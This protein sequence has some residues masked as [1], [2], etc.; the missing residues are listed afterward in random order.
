MSAFTAPYVG[1]NQLVGHTPYQQGTATIAESGTDPTTGLV[2]GRWSGGTATIGGS[3]HALGN[4]SLHYVFGP[5]QSG[6]VSLPLTGTA[7]YDVVGSTRPTDLQGNTGTFGSATLNANFTARTVDAGVTVNINNQTWNGTA[8][9]VPIYRD[10]YFFAAAGN[11]INGIPGPAL[12]NITC[13][14]NCT[15]LTRTGSLDGF[16]T[17]RSG[18]G[19]GMMYNMNGISGA[20]AF[21]RRPG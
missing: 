15:P 10:Q 5:V 21:A 14:P 8:N 13:T 12:F 11:R 3:Q 16:F 18:Q 17:G 7:T 19:A 1:N 4:S 2:W 20:I 9:G 6:P